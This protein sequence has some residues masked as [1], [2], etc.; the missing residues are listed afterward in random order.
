MLTTQNALQALALHANNKTISAQSI[1]QA[2]NNASV[3]FASLQYV[4]PVATS[5]KHKNTVIQKVVQ[6][7]VQLFCTLKNFDVY[8]KAVQRSANK[9]ATNDTQ[10]VEQFVAQSN[11]F[12]HDEQ[13]FSLVAH[14]QNGKQYLYAIYNN[15][16]SVYFI[17]GRVADKQQVAQYLTASASAKLLGNNNTTTNVTNNVTHDVKVRTIALENLVSIVVNKQQ[18]SV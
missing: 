14:K 2:L 12:E 6:A 9:I 16:S 17:D 10:N 11:Y 4:T 8:T 13:C 3:T 7:N 15:A 18:L 1:V 5:A